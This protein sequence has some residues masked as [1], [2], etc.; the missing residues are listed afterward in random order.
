MNGALCSS[1]VTAAGVG[2]IVSWR[3][4]HTESLAVGS[5]LRPGRNSARRPT[6]VT[7]MVNEDSARELSNDELASVSGGKVP[8]CVQNSKFSFMGITFHF[9]S[10]NNGD[11]VG[12]ATRD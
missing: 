5:L 7:T 2:H 12:Y 3:R 6:R 4:S 10:C 9:S 8:V 1:G 11:K